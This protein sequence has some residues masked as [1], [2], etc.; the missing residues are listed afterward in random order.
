LGI[1]TDECPIGNYFPFIDE[2]GQ[3]VHKE[4]HGKIHSDHDLKKAYEKEKNKLMA[5][6]GPAEWNRYGGWKQ[7]QG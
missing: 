1:P 2:Y 6:N 4:W 3:Y 7:G 5:F